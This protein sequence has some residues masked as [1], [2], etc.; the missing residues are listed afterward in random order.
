MRTFADGATGH[1][2]VTLDGVPVAGLD[3]VENIGTD[4][5]R[6]GHA[7]RR[8]ERR[9]LLGGLRQPRCDGLALTLAMPLAEAAACRRGCRFGDLLERNHGRA[10]S[11]ST[12]STA[13]RIASTGKTSIQ[14][15]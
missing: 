15:N 7:R 2:T 12:S 4:A 11:P 10:L 8:D 1:V 5:D 3:L 6:P 13:A 14:Q 9:R